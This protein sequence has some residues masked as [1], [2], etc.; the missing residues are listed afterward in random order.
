VTTPSRPRFSDPL[1][2]NGKADEPAPGLIPKFVAGITPE[3]EMINGRLAVRP[4]NALGQRVG[5]RVKLP[6]YNKALTCPDMRDWHW[7]RLCL[8]QMLGIVTCTSY[9]LIM[10]IP[11]MDVV[12]LWTGGL[13]QV[14]VVGKK[15]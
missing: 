7:C 9:S 13:I 5:V 4:R 6:L 2:L 15:R 8:G 14:H 1:L 3:A 12:N 10:G 11:F